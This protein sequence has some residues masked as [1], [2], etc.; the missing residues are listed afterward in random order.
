MWQ[1]QK[2][3]T[4]AKKKNIRVEMPSLIAAGHL[5]STLQMA[6]EKDFLWESAED[7]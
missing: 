3:I 7:G 1:H 6:E 5:S 2:E 4:L